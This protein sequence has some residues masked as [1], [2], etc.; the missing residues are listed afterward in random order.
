[1]S[2]SRAAWPDPRMGFEVLPV[3]GRAIPEACAGGEAEGGLD[4]CPAPWYTVGGTDGAAPGSSVGVHGRR[5]GCSCC[6]FKALWF[7]GG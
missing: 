4:V 6:G 2:C 7:R 5:G 1:M 3:A